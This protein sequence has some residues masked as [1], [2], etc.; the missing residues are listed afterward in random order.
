MVWPNRKSGMVHTSR[1]CRTCT[2]TVSLQPTYWRSFSWFKLPF[3][4]L[5]NLA[6]INYIEDPIGIY[7]NDS[8]RSGYTSHRHKPEL[9]W[10]LV[11]W[12]QHE[13]RDDRDDSLWVFAPLHL[14]VKPRTRKTRGRERRERTEIAVYVVCPSISMLFRY[15]SL[16]PGLLTDLLAPHTVLPPS[17]TYFQN[18]LQPIL[19][20]IAQDHTLLPSRVRA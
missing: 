14:R 8:Q 5:I 13:G 17:Q 4:F 2:V 20:P 11:G 19:S 1:M 16:N 6:Q 7:L 10:W 12:Q 18:R 3:W 15:D 9:F